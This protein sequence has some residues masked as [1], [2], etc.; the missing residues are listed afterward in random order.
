LSRYKDGLAYAKHELK[1]R[2]ISQNHMAQDRLIKLA[3]KKTG[4]VIYTTKNKKGVERKL[5][6]KKFSKKTRKRE[7][8]KEIKK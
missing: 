8:F 2:M 4:E 1:V 3:N 6:F 5:E 7:V